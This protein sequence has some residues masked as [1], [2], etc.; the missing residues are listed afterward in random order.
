MF[1]FLKFG[2]ADDTQQSF[3]VEDDA[4]IDR[5]I[6]S[7]ERL[8][9][10][11]AELAS[12][13]RI[14][15]HRKIGF[16]L[17]GRLEEN[18][19]ELV[20]AYRDLSDPNLVEPLT[21]SAE[22][23]VDN[24]HIV[25]EQLREIR[26]DLPRKFYRELPKLESGAFENYPRIYHLAYEVVAH[27]DNR[28]DAVTLEAFLE[29][30]QQ[31][32]ALTIGEIW[33]FPI[34]LRLA[35]IEN[36]RRFAIKI[37]QGRR[38]RADADKLADELAEFTGKDFSG[39]TFE[40][41]SKD[42]DDGRL[43]ERFSRAFLV[44]LA[45][46]L[47]EGEDFVGYALEK[48]DRR[49][50]PEGTT[51]EHLAQ[52]EYNRQATAQVSV[53][54]II[55]SMRLLS[56][57]DWRDF[58]ESVSRVDRILRK[59][60]A[61]AYSEMDFATRD[62][63]RR[64]I[65]RIAKRTGADETAIA[66]QAIDFAAN[67]ASDARNRHV[68]Y[69]LI[70][71]AGL[72]ETESS[73]NYSRNLRERFEGLLRRRPTASYFTSIAVLSVVFL[74]FTLAIVQRP[75]TSVLAFL[76]VILLAVI[77]ASDLAI[78]FV[79]RIVNAILKPHLLPKMD[80]KNGI[81][82]GART[83][84]VVPTF[85]TDKATISALFANLEVYYLANRD[86]ELFFALLG[87]LKDAEAEIVSTDAELR[88]AARQAVAELNQKYI[89][90]DTEPRFLFFTRLRTWN[91]GEGKWICPE[92]KRGNLHAF[93]QLL[94][95]KVG[96]NFVLDEG[97][98]FNFLKTIRYV[99][100]LDADTQM[101]RGAARKLIGTIEHPLNRPVFN[102]KVGR[103]TQGYAVLQ[104]RIEITLTSSLLT[105]FARIFSASK[106]F[107]PYTTAVSDVYQDLFA[108][109]SYVGKG[110]YD[111]DAFEAALDRR[112]PD[113]KLLSHD[114]FEGLYARVALLTDV[115]L[116]DDYPTT[117]ESFARRQHRW[118]RGDW[119]IARWLLPS[120]PKVDGQIVP[121]CLPLIARWKILDNLR[122]SLVA[123]TLL[124]WLFSAWIF[125][126]ISPLTATIFALVVLT[127][128]LYL[129]V[130]T[131]SVPETE[132][133]RWKNLLI[134]FSNLWDD[135]KTIGTQ[136]FFRLA[137]LVHE[138]VFATDAIV[139]ILYRKLVS[140]KRLL[141][142]VTAAESEQ[143][144]KQSLRGY[145]LFMA[146]SPIIALGLFVIVSLFHP[147]SLIVAAPFLLLWVIAP[148]IAFRLSLPRIESTEINELGDLDIKW[149][150]VVARRTWRYFETFVGESDHWLPPDN[151]QQDP[152]NILAHR[153]SPTNIGLLLL[154]TLAARDF[155]YTGT[156][157]TVE[158]IELTC[159]TL[160]RLQ[161]FRGHFYNWY[162]T[163]TLEPLV[164][165]YIS[166]VDS[167]NLA[168]HLIAVAEGCREF[169]D[170]PL[171]GDRTL[172]GFLDTIDFIKNE[173]GQI[174]KINAINY[175][176]QL[177]AIKTAVEDCE[178]GLNKKLPLSHNEW[179]SLFAG[180]IRNGEVIA[181]IISKI[182]ETPE[183]ISELIFWTTALVRLG[184]NCDRDLQTLMQP[185]PVNERKEQVETARQNFRARLESIAGFCR[186]ICD[187]TDFSFLYDDEKKVLTIGYR[188]TENVR[189]NSFYDLLASEAR[190][191]S[192]IAI[193][194]GYVEQE[195]WFRLGR[196]LV[197]ADGGRALVSWSGT[198]FEYLM[199]L[200]VMRN[201]ERT[202]LDETYRTIV[203]RQIEYGKENKVPWGVS[204]SAYNARDLQLNYQY[205]PFGIPG[206]GLK[207]GLAA[208]HVSAP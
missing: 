44:R 204:E 123:P 108:E 87:D 90:P 205:A 202:L 64:Q 2:T 203:R 70:E 7:L 31:H 139:R 182:P 191:A 57:L 55:T 59:D 137:F 127:A 81:P 189:D 130:V 39:K 195:H 133:D 75:N 122:R 121:N 43:T 160:E 45:A 155:G 186:R 85:L 208:D 144:N 97:A 194:S 141:Q 165:E 88:E 66:Q 183:E 125:E 116:Y 38:D 198:M 114:L 173:V 33:A 62:S 79:N 3:P 78:T 112:V 60:P 170:E 171:F 69:F 34:S 197:N 161:R 29:A 80:L 104:P 30:Y 143:R 91:E 178:N 20:K 113:N 22:W 42:F 177:R 149:L 207:R 107:D 199:P 129:H 77:P 72:I 82:E 134:H 19:N 54:N 106:G 94:R 89:E 162:D 172:K 110:L 13:H 73:F 83:I 11:A 190:L 6:F 92:R 48:L 126:I 192:F 174:Q 188:P 100:T 36:L 67:Q 157:E 193:A 14:G 152:Q 16:D 176:A 37:R 74:I 15:I 206:L 26:Q 200:L 147:S 101:P 95:G 140:G 5:E 9:M 18:K 17:L 1:D 118:I 120:V 96:A 51:L 50:R 8:Q 167:G 35:L 168:G 68:G 201:Y 156:L 109:G 99:I 25:E 12:T 135:I 166:T 105:P 93:S 49:L 128:P 158:R 175:S 76:I 27:T 102:A 61:N 131:T 119:Q 115:A 52:Q 124:L 28:L 142:W 145:F 181:D 98:D 40:L 148:L 10:R 159:M 4:L 84:V 136:M 138:A 63:Y 53:A 103:V 65:E 163:Q 169:A 150:R 47:Y 56:T 32:A 132:R 154:S 187:E 153:T 23:L 179:Q 185:D 46:R 146:A 58:F 151:F 41:L 111:V 86:K 21:P 24:F 71:Q 117:Y 164:P 180:L 196:G 184:K